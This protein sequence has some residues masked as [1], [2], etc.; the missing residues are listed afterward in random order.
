[1]FY[2]SENPLIR[3]GSMG[4]NMTGEN[5][6]VENLELDIYRS[7]VPTGGD[8]THQQPPKGVTYSTWGFTPIMDLANE[9][10]KIDLECSSKYYPPLCEYEWD[11]TPLPEAAGKIDLLGGVDS[12]FTL[13]TGEVSFPDKDSAT[14]LTWLTTKK[15]EEGSL[16]PLQVSIGLQCK[17]AKTISAFSHS[18]EVSI[19]MVKHDNVFEKR[20]WTYLRNVVE[21]EVWWY[22]VVEKKVVKL[23]KGKIEEYER[24][25]FLQEHQLIATDDYLQLKYTFTRE[26][27]DNMLAVSVMTS[28]GLKP[29]DKPAYF[30]ALR[31]LTFHLE[32]QREVWRG[33]DP[34]SIDAM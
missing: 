31:M 15:S 11:H 12:P 32:T 22:Q 14:Y 6:C 16:K 13:V 7:D 2:A 1:M 21:L 24:Y 18:G 26:V 33:C 34:S 17:T 20:S 29:K 19:L 3:V 28:V 27:N 30:N 5:R 9:Q 25:V 10:I 23:F 8:G 4:S